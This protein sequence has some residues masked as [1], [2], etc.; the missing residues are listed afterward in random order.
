MYSNNPARNPE[1]L[2]EN[3]YLE[4]RIMSIETKT[5]ATTA[6]EKLDEIA[7]WARRT[8]IAAAIGST[9]LVSGA[10]VMMIQY[11]R[12]QFAIVDMQNKMADAFKPS[13]PTSNQVAA[14]TY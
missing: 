8:F 4:R 5:A 11:I 3:R 10:G 12:L 9:V 6:G 13:P 1:P 7:K 14:K 2:T